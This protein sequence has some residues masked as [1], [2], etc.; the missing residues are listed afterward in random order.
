M[1]L[2]PLTLVA[3]QWAALSGLAA[4]AALISMVTAR[5]TVMRALSRML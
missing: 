1:L 2:P 3:P 5:I 4:L